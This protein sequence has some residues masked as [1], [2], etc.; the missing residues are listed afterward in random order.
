MHNI[1]KETSVSIL[2][3]K[4]ILAT[5]EIINLLQPCIIIYL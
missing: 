2:K 4:I 5:L 1:N 3:R